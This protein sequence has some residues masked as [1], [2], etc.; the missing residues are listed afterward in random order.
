M[1]TVHGESYTVVSA[2][3]TH[4]HHLHHTH[5]IS[6]IKKVSSKQSTLRSRDHQNLGVYC[7]SSLFDCG[8]GW[9][10]SLSTP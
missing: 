2:S 5:T 3:K 1:A 8:K 6:A 4:Y 10:S 9:F 7:F